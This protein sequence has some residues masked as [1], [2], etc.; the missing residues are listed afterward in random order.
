[1]VVLHCQEFNKLFLLVM[2][3]WALVQW[4]RLSYGKGPRGWFST[5]VTNRAINNLTDEGNTLI[6]TQAELQ[7]RAKQ[8]APNATF[9][10]VENFLN[11]PRYDE[12]VAELS[13][14]KEN[15]AQ[16][17]VSK[18]TPLLKLREI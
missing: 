9:V 16:P 12:I 13:G 5:T 17:T 15:D 14:T 4:V 10:A 18:A 11:S 8:K 1:M 2:L 6:V 3:G 7:E